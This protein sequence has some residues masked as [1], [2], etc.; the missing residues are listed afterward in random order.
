MLI[1]FCLVIKWVVFT[2]LVEGKT[3]EWG[4]RRNNLCPFTALCSIAGYWESPPSLRKSK[5]AL[6]RYPW[7]D[8]RR[9]D[10]E[11]PW[12]APRTASLQVAISLCLRTL[13]A[14]VR[15]L[16]RGLEF[17]ITVD[18]TSI[19]AILGEKRGKKHEHWWHYPWIS[20]ARSEAAIVLYERFQASLL[21][22]RYNG[23]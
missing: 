5:Q 9:L 14:W 10:T 19:F 15:G 3:E 21:F 23:V 8:V 16:R 4:L 22:W 6:Q 1:P 7:N 13:A 12:S 20:F 18:Q 17:G 2:C 11:R